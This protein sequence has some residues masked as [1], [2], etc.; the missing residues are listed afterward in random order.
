M[1]TATESSR[2]GTRARAAS[3]P[4]PGRS[5]RRGRRRPEPLA[6]L[7]AA[8][9]AAPLAACATNPATGERQLI[10]ISRQQEIRIGRRGAE[11]VES[12]IGLYEEGAIDGYVSEM[13][14]SM[15]AGTER[16]ELPWSF[17]VADDPTVNAFALPGGFI[18]LTRGILA[19]FNSAAEAATVVG[20]EIGHVTA[21]HSAEQ[22]SRQQLALLGLGVGSL[23][24]EEFARFRG[25]AGAGLSV[26]FLKYSRDDERQADDLGIRYMM[27]EQYDPREAPDVFQMLARQSGDGG[28]LPG[29]LS[30][31]PDPEDRMRRI[32]RALDTIPDRRLE[33]TRVGREAYLRTIEG[34][35]FGPDPRDGYFRSDTLIHPRYEVSV[36]FP[37]GWERQ[38]LS[39]MVAAQSEP[40]DAV[41]RWAVS[42]SGSREEAALAFERQEGVQVVDRRRDE[43]D[44]S[45]ALVLDFRALLEDERLRGRV[46]FVDHAGHTLQLGGYSAADSFGRYRGRFDRFIRSLDRVTDPDLLGVEPMRIELIELSSPATVAGLLERRGSPASAEA[47][48]V[49]N[50]VEVDE[51][52]EEGRT[53]KWVVGEEP[54]GTDGTE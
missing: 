6:L 26:L 39:R 25:V 4:R 52:L 36:V 43:V 54:P 50:A 28:G 15:A 2:T 19:Y 27:R 20:H 35:A 42:D 45:P 34:M 14:Q 49:M 17:E 12:A 33:G 24:S 3:G 47:L 18:Y 23:V 44:G 53:V 11:Q 8:L 10:L 31:H 37:E 5:A 21:R 40:G 30:T 1:T 9:L 46:A 51:R 38:R 16:P 32:R 29:W 7:A 41:V 22:I 13:G 48:A